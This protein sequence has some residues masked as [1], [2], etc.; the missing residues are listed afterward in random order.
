MIKERKEVATIKLANYQQRLRQGYD[1]GIKMSAFVS[2]DLVLR[3]VEGNMKNL[4]WRK[5]GPN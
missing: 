1:K 5:L 4:G 3:K 2:K